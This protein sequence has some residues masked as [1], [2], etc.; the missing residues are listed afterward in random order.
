MPFPLVVKPQN[1]GNVPEI[2]Y[3]LCVGVVVV[4]SAV[5]VAYVRN[6]LGIKVVSLISHIRQ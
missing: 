1:A 2:M 3:V 4:S 5:D 6:F